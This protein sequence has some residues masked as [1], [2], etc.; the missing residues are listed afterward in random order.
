MCSICKTKCQLAIRLAYS[1][2]ARPV[3]SSSRSAAFNYPRFSP[4]TQQCAHTSF[5]RC[6]CF[7]LAHRY[8]R[9]CTWNKYCIGKLQEPLTTT[10]SITKK[11][12]RSG[13]GRH[14]DWYE[15]SQ[16]YTEKGAWLNPNRLTIKWHWRQNHAFG[17][18]F[19]CLLPVNIT[20]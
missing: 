14:Y 13:S 8:E 1:H 15:I 20:N 5:C 3:T 6:K 2:I 12:W 4:I 10:K 18:L 16:R 17:R 7:S 9:R 11:K 19:H